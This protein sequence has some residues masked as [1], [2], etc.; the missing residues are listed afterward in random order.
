MSFAPTDER[1]QVINP[2]AGRDVNWLLEDRAQTRADHTFLIWEP[3]VGK[4]QTWTYA[5]FSY[6]VQRVAAGLHIRG[7]RP[8]D[9]VLV[10]LDNSPEMEF[11]WFACGRIGAIIV[12]TNTR[13]SE[14]ELA[15][16]ADSCNAVA[17]VTQPEYAEAVARSAK[18]IK[19]LAVTDHLTDGGPPPA[20]LRPDKATSFAT[21]D[22][23]PVGLPSLEPD[24]WRPGSV[25]FTSGTTSRPK[26]VLWT[27]G[28][29][30]WGARTSA[31]HENLNNDD[32]HLVM[33]PSFHTNARTYSILPT[34]WAGGS[35]V[36]MPKFSA[37]RFWDTAVRNECT[38]ASM[39]PFFC[40]A[41]MQHPTPD[42]HS[43]RMFGMNANEQ[44]FDSHF[45]VRSIGWW[46]M[47]ETVSQGIIGEARMRNRPMTMG[48][49]ASGYDIRVLSD[50][51][52]TPVESGEVGHLECRGWRGIQMF[53]EYLGD[54]STTLES[55]TEDGWFKTGDRVR[56]E[57]DGQLTFADRDK[58]MLRV[59][60][61]NVS[62]SEIERVIAV[63]P[64][65]YEVAVVAQ[66]HKM[67]D[68]IPVAFVIPA[69]KADVAHSGELA[70]RVRDACKEKLADFK[71]PRE[72]FVVGEM[73]RSTLE[74]VHKAALRK[75]LPVA[76]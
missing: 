33:M 52:M 50:D 54:E 26:G 59:G 67:L 74:K 7:I 14:D 20:N 39:L 45:G 9:C 65:V 4:R 42:A 41:V 17:A 35:V 72:V 36:L 25:Q 43:L 69:E 70:E 53:C 3:F 24:P 27:H 57:V 51:R 28:N 48:R 13:S 18:N 31:V 11:L 61:E 12:T 75:R 29:A 58:D 6:R 46:G 1:G 55:F 40:K 62:A 21:L 22:A 64:G 34:M 32:I 38:W 37:S 19:W 49:P 63:V 73:P 30:L 10:H 5:Q 2:F 44:P 47:T 23:D 15:Y 8:G 76:G 16:F 71:V 56:L 60:G 68:E 66:R